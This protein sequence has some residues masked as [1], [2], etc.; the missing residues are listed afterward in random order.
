MKYYGILW[1][2]LHDWNCTRNPRTATTSHC[3]SKG[4]D[5]NAQLGHLS[6]SQVFHMSK[7]DECLM[8]VGNAYIS[9][10]NLPS[11][12]SSPISW[13]IS[14]ISPYCNYHIHSHPHDHSKS[15]QKPIITILYIHHIWSFQ[16]SSTQNSVIYH[17]LSPIYHQF[18]NIL[19]T[20]THALQPFFDLPGSTF[21]RRGS[22]S[23]RNSSSEVWA[24]MARPDPAPWLMAM[25]SWNM[26]SVDYIYGPTHAIH[27]IY[28]Y[29]IHFGY[30]I[31]WKINL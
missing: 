16:V 10:L 21:G 8:F 26:R 25:E 9:L 12:F 24:Q 31:Y 4:R 28:I 6:R 22:R 7:F 5:F 17:H 13:S 15:H 20:T 2:H 30:W 3:I 23:T 14:H 29:Y 27:D 11:F 1:L 19:P 18:T